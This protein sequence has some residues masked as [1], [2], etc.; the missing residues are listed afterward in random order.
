MPYFYDQFATE[1]P[2]VDV[3]HAFHEIWEI[4]KFDFL[5]VHFETEEEALSQKY[6][7]SLHPDDMRIGSLFVARYRETDDRDNLLHFHDLGL[8]LL[9]DTEVAI[10]KREMTAAFVLKWST[11][12][13]CHGF[14]T[15]AVMA[16]GD[17][18]QSRRAGQRGGAAVSKA[19]QRT[20]F[21]HY[22]LRE[23]PNF[24][25][26][27]ETEAAIERLVNAI[28][29][30]DIAV[31]D[32]FPVS[33]FEGLLNLDER[34]KRSGRYATLTSA[35]RSKRLPVK[36]MKQLIQDPHD[37]LPPL[38]LKIPDLRSGERTTKTSLA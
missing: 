33:W 5:Q 27:E 4:M 31:P 34:A 21:A 11:L 14:L 35:F 19:A 7:K 9:E 32:E 16:R 17:D 28:A 2:Q 29:D 1:M 30:G 36:K 15:S 24:R 25:N 18:L 23:E 12:L 20:L 13:S 38:D 8:E 37:H 22:Y 6:G 26:R 3:W 10:E